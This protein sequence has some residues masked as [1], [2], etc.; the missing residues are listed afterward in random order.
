MSFH[1]GI[2]VYLT[3][4]YTDEELALTFF[5][6]IFFTGTIFNDPVQ[7]TFKCMCM[8]K[9]NILTT[10]VHFFLMPYMICFNVIYLYAFCICDSVK[11]LKRKWKVNCATLIAK[12]FCIFICDRISMQCNSLL[13]CWNFWN[14]LNFINGINKSFKIFK[15]KYH[16]QA[17]IP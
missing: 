5:Y 2:L 15:L 11:F 7:E 10:N 14:Q 6:S 16:Q 17:I 12:R 3:V 8:F 4:Y 13:F 9:C 1:S